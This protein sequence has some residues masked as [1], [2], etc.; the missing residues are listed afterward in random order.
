MTSKTP[1]SRRA[2]L[3]LA[4]LLVLGGGGAVVVGVTQD[5]GHDQ[6]ALV[7]SADAAPPAEPAAPA[8]PA[9]PAPPAGTPAQS[10]APDPEPSVAAPS[11]LTIDSI[12]VSS[13][14]ITLG[15]A[16]DG[17]IAV[18]QPGPDY[19]SAAWFDGSPRPGAVGPSVIEGH[20][21]SAKGGPSV[22]YRLGD[23]EV[24]DEIT[25]AREDGGST[26]FAV[27]GSQRYAKDDFPT[28][29]VYGNTERP[30][31]RL[32]TC[33]GPFDASTGHYRDNTVVFARAV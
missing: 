21:D 1:T 8:P 15:L 24:G 2:V 30:E 4:G 3:A 26:T 32:I 27:T 29:A 17:T 33:G 10:T 31:L 23:L 5:G 18:P 20:V 14:L 13:P 16:D 9:T 28:L 25:V 22:F 19:D 6:P 7:A 11:T 12:G